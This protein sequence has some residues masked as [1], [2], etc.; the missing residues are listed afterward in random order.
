MT[1]Q[2]DRETSPYLLQHKDN[3]VHWRAWDKAALNQAKRQGKPILLSVGYAACHWCH[4]MAHESFEDPDIARLINEWFVAVKVDREERPD[5]DAIYQKALALMGQHGGW[6]LTMFLSPEGQ[7]FFGGTYFP[8]QS[9]WG[10][11]GF[12]DV[13]KAV[14]D[15]W[16]NRRE[17]VLTEAKP[18]L[19]LLRREPARDKQ[20]TPTLD[21]LSGYAARMVNSVDPYEG[22]LQGAPKFPQC[23][24]FDRL[25]RESLKTDDIRLK[26]AVL[27]TLRKMLNGGIFDHL[28]GGLM[29]YSTD[30][31]WLVPHFEKMLY[32]NAQL[33]DLL[34]L[35]WQS[36]REPFYAEKIGCIVDWTLGEMSTESGAFA[37]T[38]D[39]DDP[40]GEGRFYTWTKTEIDALLDPDT[41][42]LFAACYD[43]TPQGNWQGRTI[44]HRIGG[45]FPD[46]RE[47]RLATAKTVLRKAREARPRPGR[48]D[49]ILADWNGMMIAALAQAGFVFD[50]P[51]WSEAAG[52][53]FDAVKSAM[54]LPD[55]RLAHSM[56]GGKVSSIGLLDDL[57][58]M[59]R[60]ALFM[61]ETTGDSFYL[62]DAIRWAMAVCTH[63]QDEKN[64]GYFQND[65]NAKDVVAWLKP[66]HD[67]ATPAAN[68]V[69][70]E[71]FAK[72]WTATGQVK[73]R[74][75]ATDLLEFLGPLLPTNFPYMTSSLIG[76]ECLLDPILVEAPKN[77]E[78]LRVVADTPLPTRFLVQHDGAPE[79]AHVCRHGA[80]SEPVSTPSRLRGLLT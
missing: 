67:S 37:A 12:P 35:V 57:A 32:D 8:P 51:D 33:L 55:G 40:M 13:L 76:L 14:A 48:D 74:Q 38:L 20:P 70:L 50:R 26:D 18:L 64:G 1:N 39:A 34:V 3:P 31:A 2:L 43:V 46:D 9:R 41:A 65:A 73:W 78:Y 68:G 28:G 30:D 69:L 16:T 45:P 61:Y 27:L 29:R 22:G 63:H 59:S 19:R 23:G 49:K 72:L 79:S 4:V 44:L 60:A 71:V 5:L 54:A 10:R 11:A 77:R 66:V 42:R 25:W 56:C 80:C 53:A 24:F 21:Q 62:D 58:Q 75:A 47:R 52:K 7:P 6:P 15:A 17:Q 36:E